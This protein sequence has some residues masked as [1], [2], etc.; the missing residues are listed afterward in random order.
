MNDANAEGRLASDVYEA[1]YQLRDALKSARE[2]H[3]GLRPVLD[4]DRIHRILHE[5]EVELWRKP[6]W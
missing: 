1:V 5:A 3:R 2:G 6:G 4:W